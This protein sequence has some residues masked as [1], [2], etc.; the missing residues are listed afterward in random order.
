MCEWNRLCVKPETHSGLCF[1]TFWWEC[2]AASSCINIQC[3]QW[4]VCRAPPPLYPTL[5]KKRSPL[6][7]LTLTLKPV[8]GCVITSSHAVFRHCWM[9]ILKILI[10]LSKGILKCSLRPLGALLR[11]RVY[12]H[13]QESRPLIPRHSDH[14]AVLFFFFSYVY[15]YMMCTINLRSQFK[16]KSKI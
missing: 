8:G 4:R 9:N 5:V 6:L 2:A 12:Q 7:W 13:T 1:Q 14:V 11:R 3:K 10:L 16:K 15:V